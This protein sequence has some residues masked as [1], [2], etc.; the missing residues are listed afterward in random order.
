[1]LARLL[2]LEDFAIYGFIFN[3]TLLL[4]VF[5]DVGLRNAAA[6][7]IGKD[8]ENLP[9]I[10]SIIYRYLFPV[11]V[12]VILSTII[13]T[14]VIHPSM[15][16][17][18]ELIPIA[19]I[20]VGVLFVRTLQG[21]F[22]GTGHIGFVNKSD[23]VQKL[24][25]FLS[26]SLLFS[27]QMNELNLVLWVFALSSLLGA[28]YIFIILKKLVP[29][30]S[31]KIDNALAKKMFKRGIVFM[32][33]ALFLIGYTKVG[34]YV[35]ALLGNSS[36]AGI[37]FG[38]SRFAEVITEVGV[39]ISMVLFSNNVRKK[40]RNNAI[41]GMAK[42][43]R[44]SIFFL[45]IIGLI[46]ASLAPYI[47]LWGLGTGFTNY[48]E[49]YIYA[50]IAAVFGVIPT[51]LFPTLSVIY[52]PLKIVALYGTAVLINIGLASS[53]FV[54][55]GMMGVM[56]TVLLSNLMLTIFILHTIYKNEHINPVDMILI[57]KSDFLIFKRFV[58]K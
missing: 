16:T 17:I 4:A 39:A 1:M 47:L 29:T 52:K 58:K 49:L 56:L 10:V 20:G 23:I 22:L 34:F 8:S 28:V 40:E 24:F 38:I 31:K 51:V 27:L 5:Y 37:Y 12:A 11:S 32:F 43:T 18:I 9:D 3:T 54:V 53:L 55:T 44:V 35:V 46:L 14:Y 7:H 26:I 13:I 45:A 33:G 48:T 30:S 15:D 19:L 21:I 50:I 36:L 42:T 41:Q 25:L 6:Y 2:S 57:K